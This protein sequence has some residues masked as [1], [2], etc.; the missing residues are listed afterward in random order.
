MVEVED[1]GGSL[2]SRLIDSSRL[3]RFVLS[4]VC[5]Y[6]INVVSPWLRALCV[7]TI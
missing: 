4:Q 2:S 3:P 6:R 1:G 7:F 5:R